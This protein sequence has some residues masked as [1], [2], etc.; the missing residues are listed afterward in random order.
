MKS[1]ADHALDP[2]QRIRELNDDFRK[3]MLG[4]LVVMTTGIIALSPP[5]RQQIVR[6]VMMFS[7]F[8]ANNDPYGER[9]F[10]SLTQDNMKI[11]F[12]IDYYDLDLSAA[13]PN[14]SDPA[15]TTRVLTI[16]LGEE[17]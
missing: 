12:K 15:V 11:I 4:G 8:T 2:A 9:D 10:A 5:Q 7:D 14:P 3:R 6:A 13:S 17:W 16:M 1:L